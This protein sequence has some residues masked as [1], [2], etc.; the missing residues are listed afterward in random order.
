MLEVVAVKIDDIYIPTARR[1]ELDQGKVDAVAEKMLNGEQQKPIRVRKGKG[2][3]VLIAGINRLEACKALG[4]EDIGA[5]IV[6]AQ[7]F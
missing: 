3:L 7:K 6:Q 2:R 4:E 1:Q 5:Y